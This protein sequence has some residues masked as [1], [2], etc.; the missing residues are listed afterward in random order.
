MMELKW[1]KTENFYELRKNKI[2]EILLCWAKEQDKFFWV[3]LKRLGYFLLHD[4]PVIIL[5]VYIAPAIL[6]LLT[7]GVI[8]DFL[9][10]TTICWGLLKIFWTEKGHYDCICRMPNE[11][12]SVN[13]DYAS[14]DLQFRFN[15]EVSWEAST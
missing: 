5:C 15:P 7:I 1:T 14:L 10:W 13:V 4:C 12:F 2:P 11:D 3:L 8:S 9:L 6:W